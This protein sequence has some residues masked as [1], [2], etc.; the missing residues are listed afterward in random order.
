LPLVFPDARCRPAEAYHWGWHSYE[1][2]PYN[3]KLQHTQHQADQGYLEMGRLAIRAWS[4]SAGEEQAFRS[5]DATFEWLCSL[6]A[7]ML[8][9]YGGKWVAAKHCG[10]IAAAD[11]LD[12]LLD[13]LEDMDLETVIIDRIEHPVWMVYR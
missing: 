3:Q 5:T 4:P 13:Q 2:S 11:S 10:V 1:L 12:A 8:R 7:D 9:R 6:P